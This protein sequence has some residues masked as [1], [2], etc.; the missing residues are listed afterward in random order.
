MPGVFRNIDLPP[1]HPR[2]LCTPFGAGGGHSRWVEKGW[3]GQKFGR[4]QTLLFTLYMKVLCAAQK[5]KKSIALLFSNLVTMDI[6][7]Y[8]LNI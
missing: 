3:G 6:F 5:N 4:R 1:P 7:N 8:F 2:R